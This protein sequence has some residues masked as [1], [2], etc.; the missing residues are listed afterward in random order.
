[1]NRISE[2]ILTNACQIFSNKFKKIGNLE[3]QKVRSNIFVAKLLPESC[4]DIRFIVKNPRIECKAILNQNRIDF[5]FFYLWKIKNNSRLQSYLFAKM[6]Y[7]SITEKF[8]K[9]ETL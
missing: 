9:L 5:E 2:Q 1:M 4:G 3:W 6:Y 7:D 8:T